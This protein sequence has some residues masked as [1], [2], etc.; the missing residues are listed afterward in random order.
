MTLSDWV[1]LSDLL[2]HAYQQSVGGEVLE[3]YTAE[4]RAGVPPQ[5]AM[6]SACDEWD[7][8]PPWAFVEDG[9]G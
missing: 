4:I 5:E 3:R 2:E 9:D 8:L 7:V 1:D 6:R